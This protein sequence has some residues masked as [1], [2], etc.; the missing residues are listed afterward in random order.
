MSPKG[1]QS[2]QKVVKYY[3]NILV[4]NADDLDN[5]F[6]DNHKVVTVTTF[7]TPF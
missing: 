7:L 3:D 1:C 5:L 6:Y 4:V 2:R